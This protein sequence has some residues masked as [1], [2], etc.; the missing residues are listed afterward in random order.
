[1]SETLK[2]HWFDLGGALAVVTLLLLI[3]FH[4]DLS[5]YQM[6]LWISFASLCLHQVEEYRFPG[7]LPGMINTVMFHSDRPDRYPLNMRTAML[8]NTGLGW[9]TY[10]LAALLAERAIWLGIATILISL[11]NVVAHTFLF[12]LK[13]HSWYNAGVATCWLFF[14]PVACFFFRALYGEH[15]ATITDWSIGLPLGIVLNIAV[16]K[17]IGWLKDPSSADAFPQRCM[18]TKRH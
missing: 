9:G 5:A 6:V 13:G 7:T 2:K 8:I 16:L 18:L 4:A 14:V 11:G 10:L 3:F 15:P 17:G 1:M 12:N